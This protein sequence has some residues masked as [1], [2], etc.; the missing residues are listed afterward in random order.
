[1]SFVE[2]YFI[3]CPY[4]GGSTIGGSTVSLLLLQTLLSNPQLDGGCVLNPSAAQL[5]KDNP[6]TYR[7][8]VLDCVT[9][10]LRIDGGLMKYYRHIIM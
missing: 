5:L 10:S 6:H 7:Q 1:M 4:L 8:M 3:L 2:R 9:A